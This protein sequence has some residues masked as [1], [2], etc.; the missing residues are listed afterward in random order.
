MRERLSFE[1]V[2][3]RLAGIRDRLASFLLDCGG[4]EWGDFPEIDAAR[5]DMDRRSRGEPAELAA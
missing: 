4:D 5:L 2:A 1:A 3:E